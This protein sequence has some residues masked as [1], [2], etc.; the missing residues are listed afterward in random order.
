MAT[1]QVADFIVAW[2]LHVDSEKAGAAAAHSEQQIHQ[3][4]FTLLDS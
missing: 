2:Y 1:A 3:L 4:S